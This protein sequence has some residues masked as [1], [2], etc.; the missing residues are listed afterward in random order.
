MIIPTT[1][2]TEAGHQSRSEL[3]MPFQ[4]CQRQP[5]MTPGR[6]GLTMMRFAAIAHCFDAG[7]SVK[8]IHH[9]M[10]KTML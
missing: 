7:L 4:T 2:I 5:I 8:I 3:K 9:A 6:Y 10:L 1:P